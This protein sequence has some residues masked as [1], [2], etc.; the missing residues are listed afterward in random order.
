MS[1]FV[2]EVQSALSRKTTERTAEARLK[3]NINFT[4]KANLGLVQTPRPHCRN[5]TVVS[6]PAHFNFNDP[7]ADIGAETGP[8]WPPAALL[9][10]GSSDR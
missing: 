2:S 8:Q 3:C 9:E 4:T 1:C 5:S 10:F 7:S 6:N